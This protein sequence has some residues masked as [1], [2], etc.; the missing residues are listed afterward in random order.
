MKSL[1]SINYKFMELTPKELIEEIKKSSYCKGVEI[2]IDINKEN[3]LN[4]LESIA[5]LLNENNLIFQVHGNSEL[6]IDEQITFLKKLENISTQ[7]GKPINVVLHPKY[8]ENHKQSVIDTENYLDEILKEI[9]DN[10][11]ICVENLN[12]GIVNEVAQDRL[13]KDDILPIICNN[14]RLY[15]TYDIGHDI[16]DFNNPSE[17]NYN[18][19]N[20]IRNIHIHTHKQGIDHIPIYKES[21][22]S[23]FKGIL[24]LKS[25]NYEETVVF[26]YNLYE[27]HGETTLDKVKD[28]LY[29]IDYVSERMQ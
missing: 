1:I 23:V 21:F 25:I 12:D 11:I 18:L 7:I 15:M 14:E 26:E 8:N 9:S 6:P 20:K 10:I 13:N 27:C 2:S 5:Y 17:I 22:D 29:S 3:E 4:Y 19:I 16:A 28:Y 24:F